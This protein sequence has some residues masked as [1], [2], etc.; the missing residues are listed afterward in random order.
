MST[1]M[2]RHLS[3]EILLD[4]IATGVTILYPFP[5]S[6]AVELLIEGALPRLTLRAP[7]PAAFPPPPNLLKHVF[8][9]SAYEAGTH[10]VEVSIAGPALLVDGHAMLCTIADRIQLE[11]Q[12]PVSAT[13]VTLEQWRSVIAMRTRMSV[14]REIGLFGEL[15]FLEALVAAGG[16]VLLS[17]WRGPG[18][19]EHDFGLDEVD[20]EVKTTS[21]EKRIHWISGLRQLEPTGQRPLYLVSLQVTHGGMTG[22]TLGELI[23]TLRQ[24]V[25]NQALNAA[26]EAAGWEDETADLIRD[27]WHLRTDAAAFEVDATFP[28]I[29]APALSAM[30]RDM[31]LIREISYR[32]DLDTR[33]Q[34][35][36]SNPLLST[37]LNVLCL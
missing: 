15:L 35:A 28:A 25:E 17:A 31:H 20:I 12:D 19:E 36:V 10:R 27:R 34:T 14:E 7:V 6:P 16:A 29:T 24:R 18:G 23:G 13:T 21:V 37:T 8:V 2:G 30:A 5:G 9:A 11:G 4:H 33:Q 26:L 32:I 22:R 1:S 3:V